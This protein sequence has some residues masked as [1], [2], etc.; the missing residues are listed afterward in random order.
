MSEKDVENVEEINVAHLAT[1]SGSNAVGRGSHRKC[2][3]FNVS[4]SKS[5]STI[6]INIQSLLYTVNMIYQ[7]IAFAI[8]AL[9]NHFALAI[10]PISVSQDKKLDGYVGYL[11]APPTGD[12]LM[13]TYCYCAQP[14]HLHAAAADE[15]AF[16][17]WEYYNYHRNATYVMHRQCQA[18]HSERRT[19][20]SSKHAKCEPQHRGDCDQNMRCSYWPLPHA[21]GDGG[22][23]DEGGYAEDIWCM[24]IDDHSFLG[25]ID[26]IEW[27]GQARLLRKKDGQGVREQPNG[28]V[29]AICEGLC[30]TQVGMPMLKG[31][32]HARSR[33]EV[34]E[35]LDDMC[36]SCRR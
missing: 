32:K 34:F 6:L 17:Q 35:G 24:T 27:N 13:T 29:S 18:N 2:F 15:G 21:V 3:L 12:W 28:D 31:D 14:H 19:C 11:P 36:E 33:Q 10:T 26:T 7:Q 8:L 1:K 9:L 25:T 5:L 30:Q 22:S 20:V 4:P 16:F 23:P